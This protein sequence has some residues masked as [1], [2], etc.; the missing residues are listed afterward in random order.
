MATGNTEFEN[1]T[2]LT[3][4]IEMKPRVFNIIRFA[5]IYIEKTENGFK[6]HQ[7]KYLERLKELEQDAIYQDFRSARSKKSSITHTRPDV[8]TGTNKLQQ[9]TRSHEG[10]KRKRY[11]H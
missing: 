11:S 6:L 3:E 9:V 1:Q 2:L 5:R 10:I 7:K 8:S 4:K